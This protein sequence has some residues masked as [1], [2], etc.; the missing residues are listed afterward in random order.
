[1]LSRHVASGLSGLRTRA[2]PESW[3][4]H[5]VCDVKSSSSRLVTKTRYSKS[6]L[7]LDI[8]NSVLLTK[9][10]I[11]NLLLNMAKGKFEAITALASIFGSSP[12]KFCTESVYDAGQ[13][14][15]E[16]PPSLGS[17]TCFNLPITS[18]ECCMIPTQEKDASNL[19]TLSVGTIM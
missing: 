12:L 8:Y 3:L 6:P 15:P 13:F 4:L 10:K 17:G 5:Y 19:P 18:T 14:C 2:L 16:Y 7:V 1:M 11:V 9:S